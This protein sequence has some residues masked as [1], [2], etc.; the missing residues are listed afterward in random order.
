TSLA[1]LVACSQ[2]IA[3]T[4]SRK[5]KVQGL[6]AFIRGLAADEAAVAVAF[7]SGVLPQGRVGLGPAALRIAAPPAPHDALSLRET[8]ARL[9]AIAAASGTGAT[10]AQHRHFGELLARCTA[11]EQIFIKRL[12]VGELRQGALEGVVIEAIA[13]AAGVDVGAVRRATMLQGDLG[14]VAE[15]A[16]AGGS[17]AL[18]RIDLTVG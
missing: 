11:P 7:L 13:R 4:R 15:A 12:V 1:A 2:A 6:A 10:R 18:S 8:H 16:F 3:A 17:Q 9:E 5:A 14:V